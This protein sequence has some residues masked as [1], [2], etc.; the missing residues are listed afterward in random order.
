MKSEHL[1]PPPLSVH[2]NSCAELVQSLE[3]VTLPGDVPVKRFAQQHCLPTHNWPP[4]NVDGRFDVGVVVSFGCLLPQ[5]LITK[6]PQWVPVFVGVVWSWNQSCCV[7][8][9]QRPCKWLKF[10]SDS[11]SLSVSYSLS[12][13]QSHC[14]CVHSFCL[15]LCFTLFLTLCFA[16][17]LTL[18]AALCPT[19]HVSRP[20]HVSLTPYH[21]LCQ[22]L[23]HSPCLTLYA[24]LFVSVSVLSLPLSLSLCNSWVVITPLRLILCLTLHLTVCYTLPISLSISVS[25]SLLK[26]VSL[27]MSLT[28]SHCTNFCATINLTLYVPS[29]CLTF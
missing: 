28:L 14:P 7:N 3:V 12:H 13:Y 11:V 15:S 9:L 6:F 1:N 17:C 10:S 18:C 22:S 23:C 5:R 4:N 16:L 27:F 24:P 20:S 8:P 19:F 29:L 2:R 21:T 26:T 25:L